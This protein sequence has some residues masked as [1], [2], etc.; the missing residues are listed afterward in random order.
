MSSPTEEQNRSRKCCRNCYTNYELFFESIFERLGIIINRYP[1]SILVTCIIVNCALMS[2]FIRFQSENNVEILYTPENSQSFKDREY[3]RKTFQDPTAENF[4][5]Y[6]LPDLGKYADVIIISRNRSNINS[7]SILTEIRQID[8]F[9]KKSI[10]IKDTGG[11]NKYYED[12]CA[13]H[14]GRCGILGDTILSLGFEKDFLSGKVS[15]PMYNGSLLS[16]I[17]ANALAVNGT[18]VSTIG[19][20]LRY[21]LRQD[22]FQSSKWERRFLENI[23]LLKA[24]FTDISY[25]TSESLGEELEKNTNGDIQFFSLTFTL[26]LTYACFASSS[27]FV[28]CN[29]VANR[30]MLGLGGVLAPI[31]G[32][33]SALGA[34]SAIGVK[35]TS[36]VGVMPFLVV[37][38]NIIYFQ[39]LLKW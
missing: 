29:N 3:L 8:K 2:G 38:N 14:L 28:T 13:T 10:F 22:S 34:V 15:F 6:Q 17:L 25:A 16:P 27:S 39:H 37:G 5:P 35:F 23:I 9:I 7:T 36:I 11:S 33:G 31:L 12:L 21:Y 24:N 26:M 1:V 20:K 32:I 30:L 19:V 18:L 4:Q